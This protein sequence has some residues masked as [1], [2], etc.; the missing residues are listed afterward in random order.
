MKSSG[1]FKADKA[2]ARLQGQVLF[3]SQAIARYPFK[4][5]DVRLAYLDPDIQPLF[6]RPSPELLHQQFRGNSFFITR[7]TADK[8]IE[9]FP[10]FFAH[11]L[12]LRLHFRTRQALSN[13]P[14]TQ[15][16]N[17]RRKKD[18]HGEFTSILEE[19]RSSAGS[20]TESET[21]ANLS[22]A[23]RK[24][25]KELGIDPDGH[26]AAALIWLH[27]IAIGYSSAYLIEN[28]DGIKRDWPR[29]PL[30]NSKNLLIES[31]TLGKMVAQ[32]LNTEQPFKG[33]TAGKL[34][35][36]FNTI[37]LLSSTVDLSLTAGWGHVGQSEAVMPGQGK[38]EMR[39]Y[40]TTEQKN[41]EWLDRLGH[42]TLDIYLNADVY[43]R[44][45]PVNVWEYRI[46][47][48]Q[49]IKKWLSYREFEILGRPLTTNEAREVTHIARRI[50]VLL[51]LQ[52]RLDNN[53][54]AVQNAAVEFGS[55][56]Q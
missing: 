10:L 7:D 43:W 9:V 41:R 5:F 56:R 17:E 51:F 42:S 37:A 12:R 33:I 49:V 13:P 44:N 31:A 23:A 22:C 40:S 36:D 20:S 2:R 14:A 35:A 55:F 16:K 54:L 15:P 32:L 11:R 1:E 45:I 50:A 34:H 52:P 21:T 39:E 6:S 30:P 8:D 19:A 53:Y 3:K 47:G 46:G 28:S 27:A 24:Y 29:I 26:A 4:P 25:L 38:S 18:G 48:Y